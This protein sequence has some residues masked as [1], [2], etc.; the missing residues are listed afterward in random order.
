MIRE[1]AHLVPGT[2]TGGSHPHTIGAQTQRIFLKLSHNLNI[3]DGCCR[4]TSVVLGDSVIP[5]VC[6]ILKRTLN[7][8]LPPTYS[9]SYSVGRLGCLQGEREN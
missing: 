2:G 3:D 4:G 8:V 9:G 6:E 7:Q 1:L 5:C